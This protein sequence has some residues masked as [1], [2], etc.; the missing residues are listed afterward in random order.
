MHVIANR[1]KM[2]WMHRTT[3]A[4]RPVTTPMRA[5]LLV[6]ALLVVV[7]G[8]LLVVFSEDTDRLFAWT[9][10][11]PLTA[12]FLGGMYL[13][14]M[15]I[16]LT[17]S[18]ER[19]WANARVAVPAVWAF[20]TL[21]LVITVIHR[22]RFHFD[23]PRAVTRTGTWVWLLVY[24]AVPLVLSA[25]WLWQLRAPGTEPS[26]LRELPSTMRR[27]FFGSGAAMVG[28]GVGLLLAPSRLGST[29]PWTLTDLTGRAVGAWMVG[30]GILALHS[31]QENDV[32]RL[33]GVF[34]AMVAWGLLSWTA[35][36]RYSD[37]ADWNAPPAWLFVSASVVFVGVGVCGLVLNNRIWRNLSTETPQE[38]P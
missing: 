38:S 15:V 2:C 3:A 23:D 37:E 25:A 7:A 27:G 20:T 36:G 24:A 17:A 8:V 13:G 33:R 10:T 1:L 32:R 4:P 21:T 28:L 34:A 26:K 35:L 16:E 6:A 12:T 11:S 18:R 29:W 30:L 31:A 5:M 19:S 14:A 9:I 22:D